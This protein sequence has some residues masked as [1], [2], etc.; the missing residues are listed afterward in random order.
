MR[1]AWRMWA[2]VFSS[3]SKPSFS[4]IEEGEDQF[5]ERT[6]AGAAGTD[7]AGELA[8]MAVRIDLIQDV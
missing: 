8:G 1:P 5:L 3:I 7:Q 6:L 4:G 2:Q